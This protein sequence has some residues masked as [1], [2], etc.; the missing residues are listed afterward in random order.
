MTYDLW[1]LPSYVFADGSFITERS[2]QPKLLLFDVGVAAR[3][4]QSFQQ[5][6]FRLGAENTA[7]L[8]IANVQTLWYASFRFIF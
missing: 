5:C 4:F 8:E 1:Q 2:L 3:P 6:E 7:D